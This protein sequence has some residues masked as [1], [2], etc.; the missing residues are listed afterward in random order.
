MLKICFITGLLFNISFGYA[1]IKHDIERKVMVSNQLVP[2]G[3]KDPAT[4]KAMQNV[5][6]EQFV[7]EKMK[8]YAYSDS[9]LSIGYGQTI[10]QPYIV[11]FMTQIVELNSED[12]VLEI[13]TGSGY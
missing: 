9:P 6:R 1:Q 5:T 10:S 11:A 12:K 2:R 7:P 3:I 4:L 8:P 13:G